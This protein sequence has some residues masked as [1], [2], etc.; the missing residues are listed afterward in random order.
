VTV[1]IAEADGE[2]RLSP[3]ILIWLALLIADPTQ[4]SLGEPRAD[5][6]FS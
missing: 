5:S 4:L 6:A 2:R 1:A 3:A